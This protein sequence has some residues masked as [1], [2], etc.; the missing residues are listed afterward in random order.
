M[1]IHAQSDNHW[2]TNRAPVLQTNMGVAA[3]VIIN[4][5][6]LAT[7]SVMPNVIE[8]YFE[9]MK[10][11]AEHVI[12]VMGNHEFYHGEYQECLDDAWEIAE[13]TGIHLMDI[14]FGTDNLE[15]DGVTFWGSAL[16]T[17][18]NN[19]DYFAK[20]KVGN[21]LND[22]HI[23]EYGER[24]L[25]VDQTIEFNTATREKINWDADVCITHHCPAMIK[26]RRF[27]TSDITYGFCNTGLEKQIIDSDIKYWIYGHTHDSQNV[28]FGGTSVV[29]NCI[30][31]QSYSGIE[32]THYNPNLILEI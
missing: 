28:D 9:M 19:G 12:W 24:K 30:G 17:D 23:V 4:A 16:W 5:G 13:K 22:Y 6:D 8:K 10:D 3:D 2:E 32:S 7:V 18:L 21:A 14:E 29:S 31:Y 1:L 25:N 11:Q 27:E 26:H 15:I 20:N